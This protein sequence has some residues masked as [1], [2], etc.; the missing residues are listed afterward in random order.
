MK[1]AAQHAESLLIAMRISLLGLPRGSGDSDRDWVMETEDQCAV[2][3][4]S[5]SAQLVTP[6]GDVER[7]GY[8]LNFGDI[9][10]DK[11]CSSDQLDLKLQ[12]S[13]CESDDEAAPSP[14]SPKD[15]DDGEDPDK[16]KPYKLLLGVNKCPASVHP[17][18]LQ[19]QIS[20]RLGFSWMVGL[21]V[22]L[23]LNC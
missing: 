16:S 19:V 23:V 17:S 2:A 9:S 18:M 1:T 3:N 22:S 5:N 11:A 12:G 10:K 6:G 8:V 13:D 7:S 14:L 21:T 15:S 4:D 20:A